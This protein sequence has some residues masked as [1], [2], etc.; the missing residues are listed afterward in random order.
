M[1]KREFEKLL[2]QAIIEEAEEQGAIFEASPETEPIPETAQ[3]RFDAALNGKRK[4]NRSLFTR[5]RYFAYRNGRR[6]AFGA[7]AAG[8]VAALVLV[9]GLLTRTVLNGKKGGSAPEKGD[10]AST[11]APVAHT[12]EPGPLET[13]EPEGTTEPSSVDA[14]VGTWMLEAVE[15]ED[16][17]Q[18]GQIAGINAMIAAGKYEATYTFLSDGNGLAYW[19]IEGEKTAQA[20]TYVV[21]GDKLTFSGETMTFEIDGDRMKLRESDL[22][23]LYKRREP[24]PLETNEPKTTP[25]PGWTYD[26]DT[27]T[28]YIDREDAIERWDKR[29]STDVRND[30]RKIVFA[31]GVLSIPHSSFEDL[32]NLKEV[33]LPDSLESIDPWAFYGCPKLEQIIIPKNVSYIGNCVFDS[34]KSVTVDPENAFFVEENGI[35]YTSDYTTVEFASKDVTNVVIPEGVTTIDDGAFFRC[36]GLKTIDLPDSLQTI[37]LYAFMECTSLES[38]QLPA[39]LKELWDHA[40]AECVSLREMRIPKDTQLIFIGED[41]YFTLSGVKR[42]ILEGNLIDFTRYLKYEDGITQ[43]VCLGEPPLDPNP[44]FRSF[45]EPSYT[46]YYLNKNKK[47]WAPNGE[48]EWNG[49]PIVGIDSLDDLPPAW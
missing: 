6:L 3:A 18:S 41:Y 31:E 32:K 4:S 29:A 21:D 14:L 12:S 16:E 27:G 10:H 8:T 15:S 33:V 7:I 11:N 40:F 22:T 24:G 49:I 39:S 47:A 19:D 36:E 42:L 2:K 23:M 13:N 30:V 45:I 44:D 48:T 28:L 9:V 17:S 35:V 5:L 37:G 38:V 46:V 25:S 20:F 34:V 26:A 43:M 1:R